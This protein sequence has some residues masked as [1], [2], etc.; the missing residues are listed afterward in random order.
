[1]IMDKT[2]LALIELMTKER[3][4]NYTAIDKLTDQA[5]ILL[6]RNDELTSTINQLK[7]VAA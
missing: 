6:K 7:R 4:D 3:H 2:R 1:M 5:K